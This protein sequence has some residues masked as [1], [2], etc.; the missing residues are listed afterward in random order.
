MTAPVEQ[1]PT[2]SA[3][4]LAATARTA[5]NAISAAAMRDAAMLW[6]LLDKKRLN[7]TFPGWLRAMIL[8]VRNYHQQSSTAAG[9]VYRTMRAQATQSPAPESLLRIAAQPS[10]EWL[11][12]A[13]GFSGPGML[14]KDT[15]QP[16]TAL[17]TTLGTTA[18]IVNDG[19]R[20]TTIN[21][22]HTDPVAVGWYRLTDGQPCAW[23]ALMASR[24][25]VY[26]SER[27]A[28]F[29]GHNS[30]GCVAA[31]AF[32][33]DQEIPEINQLALHVYTESTHG[34][35]NKDRLPAFRKAWDARS[36]LI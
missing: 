12:R 32:T 9:I 35:S 10:D 6:Q 25:V 16:N 17:S 24:G 19:S 26:K 36:D 4:T 20:T 5:Q 27:T 13:F 23:C 22:V 3:L 11:S 34:L 14:N 18:R 30:C 1:H 29:E 31:P 15:A 8:L 7:E 33:R 2:V 28:S 21:T